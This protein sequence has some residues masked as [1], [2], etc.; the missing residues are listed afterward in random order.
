MRIPKG[1][2]VMIMVMLLDYDDL[3]M[4]LN[5]PLKRGLRNFAKIFSN[6]PTIRVCPIPPYF[7][8]KLM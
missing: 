4:V 7:C 2:L 6:W 5:T 3:F 1:F 8:I